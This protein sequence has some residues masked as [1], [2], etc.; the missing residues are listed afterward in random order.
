MLKRLK[1]DE[2][3][4]AIQLALR[5]TSDGDEP[6]TLEVAERYLYKLP[7]TTVDEPIVR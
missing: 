4:K 1:E 6:A 7:H 3:I 5:S 2:K